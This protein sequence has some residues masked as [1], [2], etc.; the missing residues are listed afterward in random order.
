MEQIH[1]SVKVSVPR[2]TSHAPPSQS[3]N[4]M[5]KDIPSTRTSSPC[6]TTP[7]AKKGKPLPAVQQKH[8]DKQMVCSCNCITCAV[9]SALDRMVLEYLR[10]RYLQ[11]LKAL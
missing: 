1:H 4:A 11:R 10:Y 6:G 8:F 5:L 7:E 2:C 9:R 3:G